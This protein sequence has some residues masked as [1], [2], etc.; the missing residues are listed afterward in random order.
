[1]KEM[2]RY[3]FILGFICLAASSVLSAVNSITEPKIKV[4]RDKQEQEALKE[5]MAQASVF[6]PHLQGDEIGYYSAYDAS[7]KLIGFVLKA[8][9]KGYSSDIEALAALDLGLQITQVKILSQNETPGLGSR[10]TEPSFLERFRG[11]AI[12]NIKEVNA[13]TG[14]TISSKA[15]INSLDSAVSQLKEQLLTEIKNAR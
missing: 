6:K 12:D 8:K 10:I 13:I 14:A 5:V 15:V 4:T 7:N 1:M 9:G 3:G 2:I 11:R